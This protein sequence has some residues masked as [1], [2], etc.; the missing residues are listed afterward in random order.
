MITV[1][2]AVDDQHLN[3]LQ[4]SLPTWIKYKGF[5]RYPFLVI[6]DSNQLHPCDDRFEIFKN[7]NV[8]YIGFKC[9]FDSYE[10]QREKMLTAL[11]VMPGLY[12]KT[13]WYLKIDTDC[14]ATDDQ[15]WYDE[16]WLKK[17]YVFITNPWGSTRPSNAIELLDKWA[18]KKFPNIKP[19]NLPYDPSAKKIKHQRIISW[20]FIC[21]TE[22]SA[23]VGEYFNNDGI[24]KLPSISDTEYRVSQD[25][26]LWY[27]AEIHKQKYKVFNFKDKGWKHTR[28]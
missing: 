27:L 24:Y 28:I 10:T 14:V 8:E 19:L 17:G 1:V 2:V 9:P 20:L 23:E 7:L 18:V 15:K 13:K 4:I 26:I 12:I 6:Y 21:D 11:A 22:W 16:S 5:D 3:E 25:T